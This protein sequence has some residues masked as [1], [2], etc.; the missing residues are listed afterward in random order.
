MP[1]STKA[2]VATLPPPWRQALQPALEASSFKQLTHFLDQL[3]APVQ[4]YFPPAHQV[5]QAFALTPYQQVKVVLL[6]QDPYHHPKQAHGLSFSVPL[7]EKAPPSLRNIFKELH[8]DVQIDRGANV[9][10]SGWARQGVLL[11]N[12]TLTVAPLQ[13]GSHQQKGWE[14]FT[15]YVIQHLSETKNNLVFILW[16]KYA[17]AKIKLINTSKH[18]IIQSAHPSP[19][20][21]HGGFFG[22]QPFSKTNQYLIATQ[23]PMINWAV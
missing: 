22:S 21:A 19:L 8:S 17:Q 18:S 6:G 5:F 9:D 13:P 14:P 1:S 2:F 11:L 10:L 20:S 7:G 23:Q 16:G 3:A 4:A 12:A 15:D